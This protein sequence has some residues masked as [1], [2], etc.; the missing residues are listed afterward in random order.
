MQP[1]DKPRRKN[2]F[3]ARPERAR[4]TRCQVCFWL[5]WLY[6]SRGFSSKGRLGQSV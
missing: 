2:T 6:C 1:K 5:A 3:E 4:G